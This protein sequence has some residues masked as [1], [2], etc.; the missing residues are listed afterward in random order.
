MTVLSQSRKVPKGLSTKLTANIDSEEQTI[1]VE[2]T[3]KF[4]PRG[5]IKIG[6]EE[7]GY[8]SISEGK[9]TMAKRGQGGDKSIPI[10]NRRGRITGYK[11]SSRHKKGTKVTIITKGEYLGGD[12][13]E[14]DLMGTFTDTLID[15][16]A[17][18]YTHLTLPTKRIV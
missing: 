4:P 16:K 18:S 14:G 17:V 2:S 9:F 7:I 8:T 15:M 1:P 10:R 5:I 6:K 13:K 12:S 3:E 11:S